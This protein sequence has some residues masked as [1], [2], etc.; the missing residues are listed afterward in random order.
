MNILAVSKFIIIVPIVIAQYLLAIVGLIFLARREPPKGEYIAWNIVIV[1]VFFVGSISFFIYNAVR[2]PKKAENA[3]ADNRPLPQTQ[4]TAD[5]AKDDA[6]TATQEIGDANPIE[7][8]DR[9]ETE[10]ER[11]GQ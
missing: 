5:G 8:T 10:N 3:D 4:A 11:N 7:N 9:E 2:P 1:L 6:Q